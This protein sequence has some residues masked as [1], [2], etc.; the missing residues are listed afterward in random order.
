M[1][2]TVSHNNKNKKGDSIV[3][4]SDGT[5][6]TKKIM[7]RI[8]VKQENKSKLSTDSVAKLQRPANFGSFSQS[9]KTY[10][11][12]LLFEIEH[13]NNI[14]ETTPC[15]ENFETI[16]DKNER[17]SNCRPRP[18]QPSGLGHR[19][20]VPVALAVGITTPGPSR[21][22]AAHQAQP[23]QFSSSILSRSL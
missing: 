14:H 8:I 11:R 23:W 20:S 6:V 15:I 1:I 5:V 7:L 3:N 21:L 10:K 22:C 13:C 12:R 19:R 17:P 4:V 2:S 9:I 18:R 16:N